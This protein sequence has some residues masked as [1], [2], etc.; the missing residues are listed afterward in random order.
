MVATFNN[1]NLVGS[2]T[3][4][5]MNTAA[6]QASSFLGGFL[7]KGNSKP[8][9]ASNNAPRGIPLTITGTATSPSI[10]ADMG[11]LAKGFLK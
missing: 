10:R 1:N 8:A 2:L 3:N 7:H 6:S 11:S 5:A 9:A 4:A